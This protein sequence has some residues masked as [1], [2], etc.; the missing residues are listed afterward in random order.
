[1]TEETNLPNASEPVVEMVGSDRRQFLKSA[2][3]ISTA[4]AISGVLAPAV[5]AQTKRFQGTTI[6]VSCWN[7]T[8]AQL[9]G[10]YLK[11]FTDL[12]GIKVAY[13]LPGVPVYNQR[14]DL[15]LSTKGS[16][17]DVL[18]ITAIYTSRWIGA[19]W[20][21]PLEPYINDRSKTPADW[22]FADVL[23]GSVKPM[24]SKSGVVHGIPWIA[25]INMSGASRFDLFQSIGMGMPDTFDD[26]ENALKALKLKDSMPGYITDNLYGWTFLPFMQG[27]GG[28]VFRDPPDDLMPTL[29]TP[30]VAAAAEFFTR[31]M[32]GFGPQ[33]HANY[34]YDQVVQAL[35]A[36]RVNY[37]TLN[38]VWLALM[39]GADSKV[40]STSNF[41][42][43][44]KGPKG[45]FPGIASHAWGIPEGSKNKDAAWEFIKWA[46][47]KEMLNKLV[48]KHGLASVTRQST[49]NSAAFK[50]KMTINGQDLGKIFIDTLKYSEQ[51]HMKYRSVHVY[52]QMNEQIVQAISRVV[53]GQMKARES[54][55]LAQTNAMADLKRAG[56]K[57]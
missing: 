45:R 52:P 35:K 42:L 23:E 56:V 22:D 29:D 3:A 8:Y 38:L 26:M 53:S 55:K 36:G 54:F 37:S 51:G 27:F 6:N 5:L 57:F 28:N 16:A 25:D 10:E 31:L 14:A 50:G 44:P 21:T 32:V 19:G 33:G 15:E 39:G 17:F 41:A 48:T 49:I 11:E 40:V 24:R 43:F 34:N 47:S 9:V 4:T 1:M 2:A 18:N 30:E 20:F 12:T 13:D 46:M 7:S